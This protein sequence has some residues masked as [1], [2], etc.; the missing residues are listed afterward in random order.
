MRVAGVERVQQIS[1]RES[2]PSAMGY[3]LSL[4]GHVI[5][6]LLLL[7]RVFEQIQLI[8]VD[9]TPVEIVMEKPAE[10]ARRDAPALPPPV[11]AP[12]EQNQQNQKQQNQHQQDQPDGQNRRFGIPDVADVE[13]RAKAPVAALN[14]NGVDQPKQ[15]GHDGADRSGVPVPPAPDADSGLAFGSA[16]NPARTV[17]IGPV[18]PALPQTTAREP[19]EDELTAVK[20]QKVECGLMAKQPMPAM[21]TRARARVRGFATR[22]QALAMMRANQ[23]LLDRHVNPD[24]IANQR[25]FVESLDGARKFIVL[26][27]SGLT[28]NVGDV[29][30]FDRGYIDPSDSCRFIPNLVVGKL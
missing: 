5:V 16:S 2:D 30:E 1:L 12:S 3:G 28:V 23:A 6:L 27:P 17:V 24:Y 13:K 15:P 4:A 25:V 21:T 10:P 7:L 8:P 20:E 9:A 29:I 11:S 14:L 26:L 18:G 19:G 22:A